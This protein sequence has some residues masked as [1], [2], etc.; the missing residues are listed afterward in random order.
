MLMRKLF[1]LTYWLPGLAGGLGA[2]TAYV[3]MLGAAPAIR[4]RGE[5]EV[6]GDWSLSNRFGVAASYAPLPHVLLRAAASSK[7][8]GYPGHDSTYLRNTQYELSVGT[9][10]PLGKHWLLGGLAS[11]GRAHAQARYQDDGQARLF[12][13]RNP[14]QH[15][16]EARYR[17]L[18]AAGYVSYQAAPRTS[19][20]L[21]L[22]LT[23]LR[24][25]DLTDRGQLGPP[26]TVLRAEPMLFVR[27]RP[28][29][30]SEL[31]QLQ[32]A[33]GTSLT[34]GYDS[35][36]TDDLSDPLRQ[37][38]LGRGYASVGVLLY[39]QVLWRRK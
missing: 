33:V 38:R 39:P 3:P 19:F 5:T 21:A 30:S 13:G 37:F 1:Y 29:Q 26:A 32:A 8:G 10:W 31:V 15:E 22:R 4:Q 27:L 12:R 28:R 25:A 9:F 23:Q 17:L 16:L 7:S 18:S 36:G 11:Y 34:P 6:S 20:G 35:R 2:C 14:V 24:L